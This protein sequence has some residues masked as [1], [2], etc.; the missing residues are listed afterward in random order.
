MHGGPRKLDVRTGRRAGELRHPSVAL[1]ALAPVGAT[2]RVAT[3]TMDVDEDAGIRPGYKL[4]LNSYDLGVDIE[5]HD[6]LQRIRFEH[7]ES[8]A[9]I[10]TSA[11]ERMF[12]SGANIFML[13][14]VEPCLEGQF[15]QIH[16]RDAQRH[17]GFERAL[18][19]QVH[20]RVQRHDGRRRLRTGARVRRNLA[21]RRPLVGGEPARSA[22]A[23]RAAGHRRPDARDRQAPRAPRPRRHLLHDGR[24]RARSARARMGGWS[25]RSSSR[26]SS[27]VRRAARAG[28]R[29]GERP[30]ARGRRASR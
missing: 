28:A 13:G 6:A 15:L 2:A 1:P 9:V 29:G 26:S 24:G 5:L 23:R 22:A 10:L 27:R 11:K 21:G 4:K 30:A 8:R 14:L 20:R 25:T 16:Q 17:R 3:L 19:A 18:R 12:C 7:P